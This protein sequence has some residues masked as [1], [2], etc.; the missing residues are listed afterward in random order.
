VKGGVILRQKGH[1]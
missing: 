1:K